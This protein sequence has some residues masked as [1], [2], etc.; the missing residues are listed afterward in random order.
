MLIIKIV[1]GKNNFNVSGVYDFSIEDGTTISDSKRFTAVKAAANKA[2][3]E[4]IS[5]LAVLSFRT[6]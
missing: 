2:L 1:K 4:V 5:K 6:K 3:D